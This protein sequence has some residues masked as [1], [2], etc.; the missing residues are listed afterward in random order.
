MKLRIAIRKTQQG[1]DVV[2][3]GFPG[4]WAE[5][6]TE[7]EALEKIQDSVQ[8][9]LFNRYELWKEFRVLEVEIGAGPVLHGEAAPKPTLSEG[10]WVLGPIAID[11]NG[12]HPAVAG[13]DEDGTHPPVEVPAG[14]AAA[15]PGRV[16]GNRAHPRLLD[17]TGKGTHVKP[18]GGGGNVAHLLVST[19]GHKKPI[20][21]HPNRT[22]GRLPASNRIGMYARPPGGNGSG[23]AGQAAGPEWEWEWYAREAARRQREWHAREAHG[24]KGNG[25]VSNRG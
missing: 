10:R 1:Y 21:A 8:V 3:Q 2:A 9:Y 12:S 24:G 11:G 23:H 18:P 13:N 6:A 15:R 5:G 20:Q 22:R 19:D 7:R 25:N 17:S 14:G 16:N 4:C